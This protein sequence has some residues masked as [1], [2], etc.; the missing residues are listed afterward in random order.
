MKKQERRRYDRA[1]RKAN[2][3]K[4]RAKAVRWRKAHP[5]K[6][7]A[8]HKARRKTLPSI[9]NGLPY[10]EVRRIAKKQQGC[11]ICRVKRPGGQG[12]WHGDHDHVKGKFR[13]VLCGPCNMGLGLFRDNAKLLAKARRYLETRK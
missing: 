2:P 12:R 7:K 1:W 11:A 13:G 4:V 5:R 8:Y 9:Y 6:Y 10:A 3:D